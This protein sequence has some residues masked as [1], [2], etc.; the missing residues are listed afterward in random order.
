MSR[1]IVVLY[2]C[3]L[4]L[5]IPNG[6]GAPTNNDE[7]KSVQELKVRKGLPTFFAKALNGD[8][9]KVAYLGGSITAQEGWRV[10][11]LEWFKSRFPKA[12]F[13]E[14]NAAIG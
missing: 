5:G 1:Q 4:L 8:S 10:Y 7:T 2:L 6:S 13:S 14:I 3:F 9:I 12:V 11:S